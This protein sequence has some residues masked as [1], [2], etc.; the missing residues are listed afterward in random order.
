M[1]VIQIVPPRT[2]SLKDTETKTADS[3]PLMR[4]GKGDLL[5]RQSTAMFQR[6]REFRSYYSVAGNSRT[7]FPM[8]RGRCANII[9]AIFAAKLSSGQLVRVHYARTETEE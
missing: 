4:R 9:T 8:S 7:I 3:R 5:P 1:L 6:W 2:S